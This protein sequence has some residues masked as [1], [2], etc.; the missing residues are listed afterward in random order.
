M[1]D[2]SVKGRR[3]GSILFYPST[4]S[5]DYDIDM[6][7]TTLSW[8]LDVG[9][10]DQLARMMVAKLRD[11]T[12]TVLCKPILQAGKTAVVVKSDTLVKAVFPE[13]EFR[14]S[15]CS[16]CG[17]PEELEEPMPELDEDLDDDLDDAL[18]EDED[19]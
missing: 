17:D 13:E 4:E 6:L 1:V 18:D 12:E 9:Q 8:L 19:S 5:S 11:N 15:F 7:A 10:Y 3:E 16:K 14:D 2:L